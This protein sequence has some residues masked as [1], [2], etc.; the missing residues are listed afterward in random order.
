MAK[1]KK[2]KKNNQGTPRKFTGKAS[3]MLAVCLVILAN[4]NDN[5]KELVAE[6][7]NWS[8]AFIDA[9]EKI[10]E[11]ALTN[12]LGIDTKSEQRDETNI[13]KQIMNEALPK[14]STFKKRIKQAITDT[15]RQGELLNK[16]GFTSFY[17][18]ASKKSQIA[19]I[20]LLFQ[21]KKNLTPAISAEL[22]ASKHLKQTTLDTI[23]DYADKLS[24]ENLTQEQLKGT[25]KVLTEADIIALNN[26]YT[27]IVKNFAIPVQ[28]Y[29][30]NNNPIKVD[31]FV[32]SKIKKA[33]GTP[34]PKKSSVP[35]PPTPNP[36]A[37]S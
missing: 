32:Y 13:V 10:V 1:A 31:L 19:T 4:A 26:I 17:R 24:K 34:R 6:N 21:F 2:T 33:M 30:K 7:D 18:D 37:T 9:Q 12:I 20:E 3:I 16:L 5:V 35:P 28:D 27:T 15:T 8:Q 29:F 11:D 23:A 36:P 14:L 25:S 22:T